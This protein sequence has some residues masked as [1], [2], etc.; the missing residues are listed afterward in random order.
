MVGMT[1]LASSQQRSVVS[2]WVSWHRK[3]GFAVLSDFS[4]AMATI[5][6]V[7]FAVFQPT[8][9]KQDSKISR[10]V[11]HISHAQMLWQALLVIPV[12]FIAINP[13]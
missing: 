4:T 7:N 11:S 6:C 2:H 12:R 3:W 5:A 9:L 8:S 10:I 1:L 13:L